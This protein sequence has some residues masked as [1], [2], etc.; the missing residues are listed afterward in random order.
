MFSLLA[1]HIFST[2]I[3]I[4]NAFINLFRIK[5]MSVHFSCSLSNLKCKVFSFHFRQ[6]HPLSNNVQGDSEIIGKH[7]SVH[8]S[9]NPNHYLSH[10][11]YPRSLFV[12]S[13]TNSLL[14]A[15]FLSFHSLCLFLVALSGESPRGF[16][17]NLIFTF[18]TSTFF[19]LQ[20]L[21]L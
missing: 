11:C 16:C 9:F 6:N 10:S 7:H 20:L 1:P 2:F 5:I 17:F 14:S 15:R 13:L 12:H 19:R 3:L 8:W 4:K 18:I 21:I